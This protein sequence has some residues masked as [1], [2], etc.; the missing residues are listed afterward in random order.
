MDPPLPTLRAPSRSRLT[1]ATAFV[2]HPLNLVGQADKEV[3]PKDA[4]VL[5]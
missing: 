1:A 3:L 2:P 5:P 4:D